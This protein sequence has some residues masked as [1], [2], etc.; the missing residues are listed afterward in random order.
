MSQITAT[1]V[2]LAV[3]HPE[4]G[5]LTVFWDDG[6]ECIYSLADLRKDCPCATCR[7]LRRELAQSDELSLMTNTSLDPSIEVSGLETVGRYAIQ[8]TW[9][10]GHN[11]GI[12][13]YEFLREHC[14]PG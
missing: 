4:P 9:A 2:H 6:Q 10:D 11:T 14:T 3:D 12:Y 8:F 1:P 13:T 5:R 7:D